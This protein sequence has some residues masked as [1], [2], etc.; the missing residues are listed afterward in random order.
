VIICN[1]L[2]AAIYF[3]AGPYPIQFGIPEKKMVSEIP[4]KDRD[5]AFIT[6]QKPETY[7]Y[8]EE[9]DYYAD[10]QRSYFAVTQKK[11]GW[12]CMRH[13][14]ILANGCIP[15][16]LDLDQ[17]ASDTMIFLPKQL[18]WEAMHLPGVEFPNIDHSRFDTQRYNEILQELLDH[19]R[20]Y[21]STRNIA[22]YLLRT[23][24]YSGTGKVLYLSKAIEPDYMRECML[25]GLREL[26]GDRLVDYPKIDFLYTSYPGDIKQL[27]GK[28]FSYTKVLEDLPID[29]NSI[30]Q[31]VRDHEFDLII[32][33]SVHRG[34]PFEHLVQ[35]LYKPNAIAYICGEDGHQCPYTSSNQL[36]L[37]EWR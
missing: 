26:L 24:G 37:R 15:Y 8:Q 5:F 35:R 29:R 16:F 22:E 36:F 33:G 12:D 10:Y 4:Q 27:Y 21:L 20:K 19:T 25:I 11:G 9:A 13:Y 34:Q 18:I 31:R 1:V 3:A 2:L 6:P 17:C 28:G 30:E 7:I 32:Y 14:E 23:I